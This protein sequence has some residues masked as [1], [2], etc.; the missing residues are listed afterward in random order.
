MTP[1]MF[2]LAAPIS[3]ARP[4]E[5]A[6]PTHVALSLMGLLVTLAFLASAALA[7]P[8]EIVLE[9]EEGASKT[10]GGAS[11]NLAETCIY[12]EDFEARG[13]ADCPLEGGWRPVDLTGQTGTYW[14]E[15]TN[16]FPGGAD[17]RGWLCA[18]EGGAGVP[19]M[20]AYP[21]YGND[22]DQRL[23]RSFTLPAPSSGSLRLTLDHAFVTEAG[24]DFCDVEI[25][26]DG[27]ATFSLLAR[28][29]GDSGGFITSAVDLTAYAGKAATLRFRF[30]SD[31][32]VS[33]EDGVNGFSTGGWRMGRIQIDDGAAG[34]TYSSDFEADDG[35]WVATPAP[36]GVGAAAF[37]LASSPPCFAGP[38]SAANQNLGECYENC[39]SWVAFD[40]ATG[41]VP[42]TPEADVA[43]G[44][45]W[46]I[47]VESPPIAIP[48]DATRYFLE[49]DLYGNLPFDFGVIATPLIFYD[50]QIVSHSATGCLSVMGPSTSRYTH[51]LSIQSGR[52]G[53]RRVRREITPFIA[54]GTTEITVRL[55]L[56]DQRVVFESSYGWSAETTEGVYFDNVSIKAEN[57]A[58][59]GVAC[60]V[61]RGCPNDVLPTGQLVLSAAASNDNY[62][63]VGWGTR[64]GGCGWSGDDYNT[65]GFPIYDRDHDWATV[66]PNTSHTVSTSG[67]CSSSGGFGFAT[68]TRVV[69]PGYSGSLDWGQVLETWDA[70]A[71][72]LTYETCCYAGADASANTGY[73]LNWTGADLPDSLHYEIEVSARR[74]ADLCGEQVNIVASADYIYYDNL[75]EHYQPGAQWYGPFGPHTSGNPAVDDSVHF[76]LRGSFPFKQDG[77]IMINHGAF[78]GGGV[79]GGCNTLADDSVRVHTVV[80]VNAAPRA[81]AVSGTVQSECDGPLAGA[82]VLLTDGGGVEYAATTAADG[83][84]IIPRVPLS[85]TSGQIAVCGL[86]GYE[87]VAPVAVA[88]DGDHTV[89]F[90]LPCTYV[91]VGGTVVSGC[92]EGPLAG[93][94]VSLVGEHGAILGTATT[95]FDGAY[96]FSG[97]RYSWIPG[98]LLVSA[99]AGFEPVA[100]ASVALTADL[101]R[102]VA[103]GCLFVNVSGSVSSDCGGGLADV[104]V[105]LAV[106]GRDPVATTTATDGSYSIRSRYSAAPGDLAIVVPAGLSTQ[107]PPGGQT[108][109]ALTADQVVD[110]SCRCAGLVVSGTVS[111][112]C[113]EGPL[114]GVTVTLTDGEG[115]IYTTITGLDGNYRFEDVGPSSAPGLISVAAPLG[116]EPVASA[117]VALDTDK[118]VD[119]ACG[120][121]Y[122]NIT[123]T[124]ASGCGEGPLAGVAVSL[125][126]GDGG[127]LGGAT[128]DAAGG[129]TL[130]GIRYSETPGVLSVSAPAGFESVAPLAVALTVDGIV[131]VA[132]ACVNVTV[133]GS[134][135][136]DCRGAEAGVAVVL[137]VSGRDPVATTTGDGG[138]YTL[139]ARYSAGAGTIAITVPAGIVP[140]NPA[141]GQTQVTLTGNQVAD[142]VLECVRVDVS[143]AVVSDC[144]GPLLGV[145]VDLLDAS[146]GFHTTA[147]DA[148][149]GY[150]FED[151]LYS[152]MVDGA[153][154][155]IAIPLGYEA[156]SPGVAGTTLTL[157]QGRVVDFSL[158]CLDPSGQP[159][160]MGYWKH[161]A[162]VYLS[163][164]G[165]AQE[166]EADM[167]TN[168]PAAIFDHFHENALNGIAVSGVTYMGEPAGPL[169]LATIHATLSVKGNAGMLAKAKQQYLAFLLNVASGKLLPSTPVTVDGGT[170]SQVLQYVADLVNDGD[171]SND[172]LAKNIGDTINNAGV[173]A[174][175]VVPLD[176]Y[177]DIAYAM[178]QFA[179]MPFRVS[180]NPGTGGARPYVFSFGM[181]LAG[182]A[183]LE[184]YDVSGRRVATPLARSLAAGEH[185]V[186]WQGTTADGA[187]VA[188]GVY[189]GR[190]TTP[191]GARVVKFV[192]MGR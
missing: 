148:S 94:A 120:C 185:R 98:M 88:L 133:S 150:L 35:G 105:A 139:L 159:R 143:G 104:S 126:R 180:P 64:Y 90:T 89:D 43:D 169:D 118:T 31:G 129:Y 188:R 127:A 154:V 4:K 124:V 101:T 149:G 177:A 142:F 57:T 24:F 181:P 42:N 49:Y 56:K 132:C 158:A 68:H 171:A 78:A 191:E 12:H 172:E 167:T 107:S 44:R 19:C 163:G 183:T 69:A 135:S 153:E 174:A 9:G 58:A 134:V 65:H 93:V 147:T 39:R 53:W 137:A 131:D 22:W 176:Q 83:S 50:E 80:R 60:D 82:A 52:P 186:V 75:G 28:Y 95:A 146:S 33:S 71:T 100:P 106:A 164:R 113:G 108:Q 84:Y 5:V 36:A 99:P 59:A 1:S 125:A 79:W 123:G 97:I 162:S 32:A 8:P 102:D 18:T 61:V 41:V 6:P 117:S 179:D 63:I 192:Q 109:V 189:F 184:V 145:T 91:S 77:K 25:S 116:F 20:V 76:V 3:P 34:I 182:Q 115:G 111:S 152:A 26:T 190:L 86:P 66:P 128:T 119:F 54:P 165:S 73:F 13:T 170:A 74:H 122:V 23:S 40:P 46:R 47:A 151:L 7:A 51:R 16:G 11:T 168:Y 136:S 55:M 85:T 138:A 70:E 48:G 37:R 130:A 38:A 166:S 161:N 62:A 81:A 103:C 2:P 140:Q 112:A 114:A 156:V 173:I 157:D 175:G 141:G 121:T 14:Q 96:S 27:G 21:G 187:R 67:S 155:S 45:G 15:S 30:T 29:D 110:F 178:P 144:N 160:S 87:A 17:S 92:G 72:M 10:I